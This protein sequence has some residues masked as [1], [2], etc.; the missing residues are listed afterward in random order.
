M[1]KAGEGWVDAMAACHGHILGGD[2]KEDITV[3]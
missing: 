3:S 1:C 2:K